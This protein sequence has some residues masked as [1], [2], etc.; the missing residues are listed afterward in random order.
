MEVLNS[1]N[2][3]NDLMAQLFVSTLQVVSFDNIRV[4]YCK[5]ATKEVQIQII[6][7][8]WVNSIHKSLWGIGSFVFFVQYV[9]SSS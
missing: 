6:F 9:H 1:K 2:L 4:I 7:S 3:A 8:S 5:N